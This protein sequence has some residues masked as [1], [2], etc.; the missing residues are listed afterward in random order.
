MAGG[1]YILLH[2]LTS[3][4]VILDV[5]LD[6]LTSKG[7][8][9]AIKNALYNKII[10]AI[11]SGDKEF[12]KY[13]G[14]DIVI[15][16]NGRLVPAKSSNADINAICLASKINTLQWFTRQRGGFFME[17]INFFMGLLKLVLYIPKLILWVLAL[18]LWMIKLAFFLVV[19]ALKVLSKDGIFGLVKF[20]TTDILLAPFNLVFSLIKIGF[21]WLGRNTVQ[22]I[23]GADNVPEPDEPSD[24]IITG[25]GNAG[26]PGGQKCYRTAEGT[27]PFSVIIATVLCPPVGVFME[28]GLTG[29]L[30][31]L[32]CALLTLVFY[33][34]GLI[35]ALILLYC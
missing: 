10:L 30:N 23:W 4:P 33:F 18:I 1:T 15:S 20:I 14:G 27:I 22:A 5:E 19:Y 34:P 12:C 35:Y 3:K 31:I 6:E 32:I 2:N 7:N 24:R 8:K 26:C 25:S 28:Y 21:N 11:C 17:I 13:H 9:N 29:W 16:I